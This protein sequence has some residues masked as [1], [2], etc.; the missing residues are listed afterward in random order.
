[1]NYWCFEARK[2]VAAEYPPKTVHRNTSFLQCRPT[3][4]RRPAGIAA[5]SVHLTGEL[6]KVI[7]G[8]ERQQQ[9]SG[10]IRFCIENLISLTPEMT[11]FRYSSLAYDHPRRDHQFQRLFIVRGSSQ[12]SSVSA[13]APTRYNMLLVQNDMTMTHLYRIEFWQALVP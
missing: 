2:L 5:A 4:L 7:T 12:A 3:W 6:A 1:L 8:C 11:A 9:L 10:Q 13:L